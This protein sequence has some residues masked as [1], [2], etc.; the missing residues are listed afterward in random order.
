ML[1][2]IRS[3]VAGA[4]AVDEL[5]G[6]TEKIDTAIRQIQRAALEIHD[7]SVSMEPTTLAAYRAWSDQESQWVGLTFAEYQAWLSRPDLDPTDFVAGE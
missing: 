3:E 5:K 4:A 2:H 6:V 1:I 7:S